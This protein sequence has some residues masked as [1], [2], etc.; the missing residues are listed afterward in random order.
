MALN[1]LSG[2]FSADV[3]TY[4]AQKVLSVALK[5]MV[6]YNVCDKVVLPKNSGRTF[7]Y[8]RY[9]RVVLP[10]STLS[11]GVTPGDTAMSISTVSAVMDQWGAVIPLSDVA[12][13]SVKHPVLQKAMELAGMQAAESLDREVAL[14]L[15]AGT[16]VF[17]PNAISARGSLTTSDK[18]DTPAIGKVVSALRYKGARPYDGAM[19]FGVIDP[20]SEYDLIRDSLFTSA[21]AYGSMK[22]LMNQEIGEWGGVRWVRSNTLPSIGLATGASGA[23]S[24]TAGSLSASTTYN[25]KLAVVNP[26]T[27]HEDF[28]TATFNAATGMGQSS[29]DITVPALPTGAVAGSK[30]RLYFGSNGG[31]LYKA[32]SDIAASSTYNQ[33]SVPTSGSVAQ[34]AAPASVRVHHAF[35]LGKEGLACVELNKIQAMLTPAVPSDSDPLMQRRKVGWKA[36]FKCVITNDLFVARL[37]HYTT[38]GANP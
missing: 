5:E 36:D 30:F 2:N 22:K 27:G 20:Y 38:Y 14:V 15:L 11:E 33:G 6:L 18:L 8:T 23:G 12:I 1:T 34:A 26:N 21:A 29:V 28:I 4:I 19:Y 16:N 10:Q 13:D 37:E 35:V 3:S 9:E 25:A 31:T 24:A 7:Q 32:A 17:Y